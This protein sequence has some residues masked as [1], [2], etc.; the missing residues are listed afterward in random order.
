MYGFIYQL[1]V[2]G[3]EQPF[4]V[5]C[6]T[7]DECRRLVEHK[8]DSTKAS[9]GKNPAKE[10]VIL[11]ARAKGAAVIEEVLETTDDVGEAYTLERKWIA[12]YGRRA[13]G[14]VLTN[15][16]DGGL[17][18]PGVVMTDASRVKM[19]QA[20][21][22]NKINEGRRRPDMSA[23]FSKSLTAFDTYGVVVGAYPSA[24]LAGEELHIHFST[25]SDCVKGRIKCARSRDG[26]VYQ[27]RLGVHMSAIEPITYKGRN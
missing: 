16:T 15:A 18:V 20:K 14:G 19:A 9:G 6:T 25:I 13:C 10:A 24:R 27:F 26:I 11:E 8:S 17:G 3:E 2:E 23:R 22:G 12:H 1:R 21:I 4:Y 5:G 7:R